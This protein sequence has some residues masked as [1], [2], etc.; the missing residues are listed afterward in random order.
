MGPQHEDR[1]EELPWGLEVPSRGRSWRACLLDRTLGS[2]CGHLAAWVPHPAPAPPSW[3]D[4]HLPTPPPPGSRAAPPPHPAQ[5]RHR[6]C[7][8][9][10]KLLVV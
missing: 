9:A 10:L 5:T 2:A 4:T 8:V 1:G 3:P 6:H 7:H